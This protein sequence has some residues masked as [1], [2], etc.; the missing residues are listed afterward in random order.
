MSGTGWTFNASNGTVTRTDSL[1]PGESY[2][3]ITVSVAIAED[4]FATLTNAASVAGSGDVDTSDN[5]AQLVVNIDP[6]QTSSIAAWR[7]IH[8]GSSADSGQGADTNVIT[9]D[10]LPNLMK[11]AFGLDPNA[12]ASAVDQPRVSGSM[13]FTI[14]FRRARDAGDVTILV[15][16]SDS[17]SG[18]WTNIWTSAANPFGGGTNEHETISVTDPVATDDVSVGRFLRIDVTRP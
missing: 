3:P 2:P 14:S 12:E 5:A 10:G 6:K 11:Y 18:D 9:V 8:F 1:A 7:Q 17:V 15:Q 13:P 16:G 4:A